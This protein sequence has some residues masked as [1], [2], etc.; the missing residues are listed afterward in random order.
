MK[1][2]HLS[3]LSSALVVDPPPEDILNTV[4]SIVMSCPNLE[5]L[6]GFH[7]IYGHRFDRLT[8][9]LSTRIRLQE[10]LWLIGENEAV[11][12]RSFQQLSPGLM[13]VD[14]KTLFTGFHDMWQ[15]LTTLVLHSQDQGILERD[16]FVNRKN[17]DD[18]R[19]CKG[20]GILHR[21]PSL[22]HLCISSFD[23]DDFD[24]STLQQL[25]V[26]RS[27]RLQDLEGVTFWGLS[28]FSKSRSAFGIRRLALVNL[29]VSN[30]LGYYACSSIAPRH[31]RVLD[32]N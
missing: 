18:P 6:T 3:L 23:M 2:L 21:L 25:P 24:D 17:F 27:L 20:L 9:A 7:I 11:T 10:H 30:F 22:K 5:R 32:R 16:V 19:K 8:H 29:D 31:S 14:Q 12:Q 13:D 4:A 1:E 28:E 26:L 15:S